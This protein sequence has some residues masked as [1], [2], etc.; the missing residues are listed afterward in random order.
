MQIEELLDLIKKGENVSLEFKEKPVGLGEEIVALANAEGGHILVGISDEG[1]IVGCDARKAVKIL[2]SIMQ[3]ITPLPEIKTEVVK[4]NQ[5]EVLVIHVSRSSTLVSTGSMAYIRIGTS[6]RPLSIQEIFSLGIEKGEFRWDEQV[7]K[8]E[9]KEAKKE[10]IE[11]FFNKMEEVRGRK[12]EKLKYLRAIKAIKE[13]NGKIYLTNAGVLFFF[14]DP[15]D[16]FPNSG[17]RIIIVNEKDE[18]IQQI[19]FK[20][21]IWKIADEVTS[22]FE[23]NLGYIEVKVGARTEKVLEYPLRAL[24]EAIVNALLHRNYS[25]ESDVRIFVHKDRIRIRSPGGLM[26]GVNLDEP[27]HVPRNPVLCQLMFDIGYTEKYGYGIR[28]M[29]EETEAHP[30][31]KLYFSTDTFRFDVIFS[32]EKY[33]DIVEDVDRKILSF[34]REGPKT[35]SEIAKLVGLSKQAI[36]LRMKK[37]IS[38]GLVRKVGRGPK[39]TYVLR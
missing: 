7:S 14:E 17:A 12:V 18:P 25:L 29:R 27:E 2:S 15:Q 19:E 13:K 3:N 11:F 9:L 5:K 35:S 1:K 24:R 20:G 4:I 8:I 26:P 37:L 31:A 39:T 30:I 23:K 6:K 36:V 10:F 33:F 16:Y 22:W 38:L 28:M 34:L 32:K 21:T